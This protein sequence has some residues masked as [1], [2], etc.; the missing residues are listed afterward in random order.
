[1][2]WF[3]QKKLE[4]FVVKYFAAHPDI[5]LVV[6]TGSVGKTS[7]KVAIGTVLV[8]RFRVRLHEGNHNTHMSTPLAIL[9]IEYPS[10]IRSIKSWIAVFKAAK[11]RIQLPSDVDIIVQ[12][13]GS[14]RIG[15]VPHFGTYLHPD[16]AVITAV[17][18]EHME[19]FHEMDAVAREELEVANF[20]KLALINRDDIDQKYA[21]YLTNGNVNTY[22]TSSISEYHY[23]SQGYTAENGHSG[24]FVAPEW[25]DP[26][27]ADVHVLGEHT[28]RPAIAAGAVGVKLGMSAT[29]IANGLSKIHPLPGRMNILHGAM[30]TTIIDDTYNSSPLAVEASL[31]ELYK[32][33]VPQRIAV[34]GSMNELGQTSQVEHEALGKLCD[35]NGLAWVITVGDEAEKYLAPAARARGC[36]VKSFKNAVQA[37]AFVR[38]VMEEGAAILFKG[39][40]GGIYLE[41]AVKVVLHS[42]SD[43]TK[44]VRQS[45]DWMVT[46]TAFFSANN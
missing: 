11:E 31:H 23:I 26:I 25:Q 8:E 35:P 30:N 40:Q 32:L 6:V 22:G 19:Y 18:P 45:I 20:S 12:E 3:I 29:E 1:M 46:K 42:T 41:E 16:I 38:G 24:A 21:K 27:T 14:D 34:L 10:N 4:Q 15:E 13:L 44:L 5:K 37:G 17:S 2:K 43:E 39:S 7:T 9:G 28:L 36:Q 33:S